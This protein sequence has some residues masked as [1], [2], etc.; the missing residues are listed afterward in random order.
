[1]MANPLLGN[2]VTKMP[3]KSPKKQKQ[4]SGTVLSQ[5]LE[6]EYIM[7]YKSCLK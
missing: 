2:V 6:G 7:S 3:K 5:L 1:M 4:H